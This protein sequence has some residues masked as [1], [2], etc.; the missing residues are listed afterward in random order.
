[1]I[2]DN[3]GLCYNP[4]FI[5]LGSVI[6][7]LANPDSILIGE[8]NGKSGELLSRFYLMTCENKPL[9]HRMS[10]ENA[11]VAKIMLNV[12]VTTKISLANT[13]AEV[14]NKIEGGDIDKV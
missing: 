10:W 8:S 14:C 4:E 5:A 3:Y 13:F 6:H 1:K 12:F 2:N 9:I 11:E 7:D